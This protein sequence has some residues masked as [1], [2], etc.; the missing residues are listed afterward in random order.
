M[1]M[2]DDCFMFGF[3]A[4]LILTDGKKEEEDREL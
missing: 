4:S 3:I 1:E 2:S